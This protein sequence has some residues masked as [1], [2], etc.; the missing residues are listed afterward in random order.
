MEALRIDKWLWFARFCKTRTL[1]AEL[2]AGGR[3]RVNRRVVEKA[4]AQVRVGDVLTFPMGRHVRVIRVL[5]MAL[6]RGPFE[7][8]RLLYEDLAPPGSEASAPLPEAAERPRGAG[9]PS[10]RERRAY[11]RLVQGA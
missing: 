10:K 5:A 3:V 8:A 6:Q 4:S 9:R 2:C 7:D 11:E 1:A